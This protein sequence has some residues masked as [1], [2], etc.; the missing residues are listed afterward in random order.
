MTKKELFKAT[1]SMATRKIAC[2]NGIVVDF[3]EIM[4]DYKGGLYSN[5]FGVN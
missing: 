5:D 4:V 3:Y 2:P 1:K